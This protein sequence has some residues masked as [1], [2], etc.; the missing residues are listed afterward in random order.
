MS[1]MNQKKMYPSRS[2]VKLYR[3][4]VAARRPLP[5]RDL[6]EMLGIK[7]STIAHTLVAW[8]RRGLV[9]SR[10][11]ENRAYYTWAPKRTA[12]RFAEQ[13]ADAADLI[14]TLP[15]ADTRAEAKSIDPMAAALRALGEALIA[16][17]ERMAKQT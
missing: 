10:M 14:K 3:A 8:N 13:L 16:A 6:V 15:N 5:L 2:D 7:Q 1:G 11:L 4:L 9:K 12:Q 17:A